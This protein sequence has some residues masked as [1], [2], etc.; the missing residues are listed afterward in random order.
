MVEDNFKVG[1]SL[2]IEQSSLADLEKQ[3]TTAIKN[4][5]QKA[6]GASNLKSPGVSS[7]SMRG[8]A[9][10]VGVTGA[11]FAKAV[12]SVMKSELS[13][14]A[15]AA[16]EITASVN[17]LTQALDKQQRKPSPTPNIT[18]TPVVSKRNEGSQKALESLSLK[19][20]LAERENTAESL[21]EAQKAQDKMTKIVTQKQRLA[22]RSRSTSARLL[23]SEEDLAKANQ[24]LAAANRKRA[25]ELRKAGGLDVGGVS[26][27]G[28]KRPLQ[29]IH[30]QPAVG[31]TAQNIKSQRINRATQGGRQEP[32]QSLTVQ[33]GKVV[34]GDPGSDSKQ[35][36]RDTSRAEAPPPRGKIRDYNAQARID[37]DNVANALKE[38]EIAIRA[39]IPSFKKIDLRSEFGLPSPRDVRAAPGAVPTITSPSGTENMVGMVVKMAGNTISRLDRITANLPDFKNE[40]SGIQ[41]AMLT[42]PKSGQSQLRALIKNLIGNAQKY[43]SHQARG[44]FIRGGEA[45]LKW[46]PSDEQA[47]RILAQGDEIGKIA[48]I[49]KIFHEISQQADKLNKAGLDTITMMALT[50]ETAAKMAVTLAKTETGFEGMVEGKVQTRPVKDLGPGGGGYVNPSRLL[51]QKGPSKLVSG[52]EKPEIT[53]ALE[54]VAYAE[55]LITKAAKNLV[56]AAVSFKHIPE[57]LEDQFLIAESAAKEMGMIKKNSVLVKEKGEDIVPGMGLQHGQIL[58]KSASGENVAMNLK[59]ASAEIKKI[60]EVSVDGVKLIKIT[61]EE[62]NNMITGAKLGDRAGHKGIAK[63]VPDKK[64]EE[65]GFA[66]GTQLVTSIEGLMKRNNLQSIISMISTSMS[67]GSQVAAQTIYDSIV[68]AMDSG[69]EIADAVR[70]TAKQFGLDAGA[71]FKD[72][73][74]ALASG[75]VGKVLTGRVA[76]FRMEKEGQTGEAPIR[77]RFQDPSG[78]SALRQREELSSFADAAEARSVELVISKQKDYVYTLSHLINASDN[79]VAGLEKITPESLT[80]FDP[81]GVLDPADIKG[82]LLDP[83]TFKGA[84]SMQ[85]PKRAGGFEEMYVPGIGKAAGQRGSS[86]NEAGLVRGTD[87]SNVWEK[88]RATAVQIKAARGEIDPTTDIRAQREGAFRANSLM[89]EQIEAIKSGMKGTGKKATLTDEGAS[90]AKQFLDMWMP[91]IQKMEKMGMT[92]TGLDYKTISATGVE[93]ISPVKGTPTKYVEGGSNPFEQAN[94]IRDLLG[95]RAGGAET[96]KAQYR[97]GQKTGAFTESVA[98]TGALF[99]PE[100]LELVVDSMKRMGSGALENSKYMDQLWSRFDKLKNELLELYN[101]RGFGKNAGTPSR[102]EG[103]RVAQT[104]GSGIV[105]GAYAKAIEFNVDVSQELSSAEKHLRSLAAAGADVSGSL[106]ALERIKN[107]QISED[108]IPRDAVILSQQDYSNLMSMIKNDARGRG[109]KLTDEEARARLSRVVT[110]R[111]PTTGGGSYKIAKVIED[112]LGRLTEGKMGIPGAFAISSTAD[113]QKVREPLTQRRDELKGMLKRSGGIGAEADS[114]RSELKN[115]NTVIDGLTHSFG[116]AMQNLDFDGDAAKIFGTDLENVSSRMKTTLEILTQGGMS[117]NQ[118][119]KTILGSL[120]STDHDF[121]TLEGVQGAFRSIV[122]R[123]EG[124]KFAGPMK[125]TAEA[126]GVD[127]TKLV[128]GKLS[129]GKLSD[130]FNILQQAITAGARDTGDAFATGLEVVMQNINKSLAAKHGTGDLAGPLEIIDSLRR[131]PAGLEKMFSGMEAGGEGAF[132]DLGKLNQK[133]RKEIENQLMSQNPSELMVEAMKQGILKEGEKVDASNFSSVIQSLVDHLDLKAQFRKM[134]SMIESNMKK[135][136]AAE[137]MQPGAIESEM[138]RMMTNEKDPG[139]DLFRMQSPAYKLTRNRGAKALRKEAGD[140]PKKIGARILESILQDANDKATT[141]L[142]EFELDTTGIK[143]ASSNLVSEVE[144]WLDSIRSMY[145]LMDES[146]LK[147]KGIN[148]SKAMGAF[149]SNKNDPTT[150]RIQISEKNR[151]KPALAAVEALKKMESGELKATPSLINFVTKS[152]ANLGM[153]LAHERIHEGS[154][155]FTD[156]VDFIVDSLISGSGDIGAARGKIMENANKLQNVAIQ[157]KKFRQ[158]AVLA[159]EDPFGT[160]GKTA[161]LEEFQGMGTEE[162]AA[163]QSTKYMRLVAEELQAHLANPEKWQKIFGDIPAGAAT[164]ISAALNKL[165]EHNPQLIDPIIDAVTCINNSIVDT[166][167][168]ALRGQ[169]TEAEKQIRSEAEA[170]IDANSFGMG[171]IRERIGQFEQALSAGREAR[172]LTPATEIEGRVKR[173]R[174]VSFAQESAMPETTGE[175]RK[176]LEAMAAKGGV[177]TDTHANLK[178]QYQRHAASYKMGLKTT[179]SSKDAWK[180]HQEAMQEFQAA[181]L[182]MYV[183]KARD[184]QDAIALIKKSGDVDSSVMDAALKEL[185]KVFSQMYMNLSEAKL[186]GTFGVTNISA[187]KRG[188]ATEAAARLNI[189]VAPGQY[190]DVI[191]QAGG[192]TKESQARFGNLGNILEDIKNGLKEDMSFTQ[193]WSMLWDELIKRP[194]HMRENVGKV[195]EALKPM[196]QYMKFEMG[197]EKA[198]QGLQDLAKTASSAFRELDAGGAIDS[199]EELNNVIARSGKLKTMAL[200]GKP[201]GE[202]YSVQ[203]QLIKDEAIA[204]QKQLNDILGQGVEI[205][206]KRLSLGT[207]DIID[208]N[209][210]VVLRKMEVGA[211]R[212]GNQFQVSMTQAGKSVGDLTGAMRGA[213]RR[214]VQWGFA[215]GIVYGTVRAFRAAGSIIQEVENK[216]TALKKVMDTSVTNFRELQDGAVGF[217]KEFGVSIEDVLDGMVVYGQQGLKVNKIMERTRATMLAVNTTTL[218]SVDATEAL[219]AAHKVF[220][221][222]IE[223]SIHFVDAWAAVAARHAITAEDL[224]DAVKRSGAAAGVAGVGFNDFLGVVTAI[225]AVTRQSG[226]E[227]ATGTKFMFRAMRRPTAQK[228][229]GKMGIQSLTPGGDFKPALGILKEIAGS[230]DTMTKAQQVNLA[231]AMAGIRHYNAFIVLMNNFDEALLASADAANSQGFAMRKN[232]LAMSTFTKNMTVLQETAKGLAITLGNVLLPIGKGVIDIMTGMTNAVSSLPPAILQA[233]ALFAGMGLA[234]HKGA[235]LISDSME[236]MS[237]G[238]INIDGKDMTLGRRIG[239]GVKSMGEGWKAAGAVGDAARGAEG[240]TTLGKGAYYAQKGLSGLAGSAGKVIGLIPGL[241]AAGTALA[242]GGAAAG[243]VVLAVIAAALIGLVAAYQHVTKSAS[244]FE[245]EQENII[246]RSEDVASRLRAQKTTADRLSLAYQK[247]GKAQE[248]MNDPAAI[249]AA[250]QEGRFKSSAKAAQ[251]YGNMLSEVSNSMARIDPSSVRGISDTGEYILHISDNFKALT[252]SA[253]D[254]RNAMT[255]A[256]KLDIIEKFA[257]ELRT[258]EGLVDNLSQGFLDAANAITGGKF[259][260]GI[261]DKGQKEYSPI[262][263]LSAVRK[264]IQQITE[265]MRQQEKSGDYSI[266]KQLQLNAKVKEEAALRGEVL[267]TAN[268]IRRILESM[269]TFEDMGMGM[270]QISEQAFQNISGAAQAGAFGRGSTGTSVLNQFAA[271]QAGLGGILDYQATQSPGL[272]ASAFLERGIRGTGGAGAVLGSEKNPVMDK[273]MA[274]ISKQAAEA[275]GVNARILWAS[276]EKT[277]GEAMYKYV[278]SV[279]GSWQTLAGSAVEGAIRALEDNSGEIANH[280]HRFATSE[281]EAASEATKKILTLQFSGAMAG[282]RIPEGGMPDL[283]PSRSQDLTAE[284]RV[285]RAMPE[286]LQRLADVQSEFNQLAKEYSEDVLDD[287]EGAYKRQAKSGSAL[288]VM[289]QEVL[290]LATKLQTEGHLITVM[291]QFQKASA[292]LAISLEAAAEASR[293]ASRE[294]DN[295]AKYLKISSGALAGM[296]ELPNLDLGKTMRELTAQETLAK[297]DPSIEKMIRKITGTERQRSADLDTL[298]DIQKKMS[299]LGDIQK[300][301]EEAGDSLSQ[302]QKE[303]ITDAALK[304]ATPGELKMIEA[305]MKEGTA[306]QDIMSQ[307]LNAQIDMLA[308]MDITNDLLATPEDERAGKFKGL[309]DAASF[310]KK[311]SGFMQLAGGAEFRKVLE[312]VIGVR[313]SDGDIGSRE[314]T[315]TNASDAAKTLAELYTALETVVKANPTGMDTGPL[316]FVEGQGS[317]SKPAEVNAAIKKF[318]EEVIT[319]SDQLNSAFNE[320]IT[321]RTSSSSFGAQLKQ[322]AAE[323]SA[324]RTAELRA[325]NAQVMSGVQEELKAAEAKYIS[326]LEDA[327]ESLKAKEGLRLAAATMDFAKSLDSIVLEMDKA[328]LLGEGVKIKSDLDSEFGRVGQPGFKNSFDQRREALKSGSN[329]PMSLTDLRERGLER[330]KIDFDEEEAAIKQKQAIETAALRQLQSQA[331]KVRDVLAT[332]VLDTSMDQGTRS[333]AQSYLETLTDQLATSEQATVGRNGEATFKG[334]PALNE[335]KAFAQEMKQRSIEQANKAAQDMQTAAVREGTSGLQSIAN[336][337]LAATKETNRILSGK[338]GSFTGPGAGFVTVPDTRSVTTAGTS[339]AALTHSQGVGTPRVDFGYGSA[340]AEGDLRSS[341]LV[342]S[343]VKQVQE[344]KSQHAS[345]TSDKTSQAGMGA[346]AVALL[347]DLFRGPSVAASATRSIETP[348]GVVTN[349]VQ[350]I[351]DDLVVAAS[352]LN[353]QVVGLQ[354]FDVVPGEGGT[355]SL[356]ARHISGETGSGLELPPEIQ[357]KGVGSG[358]LAEVMKYGQAEGFNALE[359]SDFAS[360]EQTGAYRS[361]ARKT[362]LSVLDNLEGAPGSPA[363]SVPLQAPAKTGLMEKFSNF[364]AGQ[365]GAF[366]GSKWVK[367]GKALGAIGAGLEGYQM[368]STMVGAESAQNPAELNQ[369]GGQLAGQALGIGGVAAMSAAGGAVAGPLGALGGGLI[370]GAGL[371]ADQLTGAGSLEYAGKYWNDKSGG[372][373]SSIAQAGGKALMAPGN[374]AGDAMDWWNTRGVDMGPGTSSPL[375]QAKMPQALNIPS[376]APKAK[377]WDAIVAAKMAEIGPDLYSAQQMGGTMGN[378]FFRSASSS[379]GAGGGTLISEGDLAG[380]GTLDLNGYIERMQK[381]R[382]ALA[383]QVG[384]SNTRQQSDIENQHERTQPIA[385]AAPTPDQRVAQQELSSMQSRDQSSGGNEKLVSAIDSLNSKIEELSAMKIDTTDLNSGLNDISSAVAKLGTSTLNVNVTGGSMSVDVISLPAGT[386]TADTGAGSLGADVTALGQRIEAV[387]ETARSLEGIVDIQKTDLS[388]V[389]IEITNTS[390]EI[391]ELKTQTDEIPSKISTE[392]TSATATLKTELDDSLNAKITEFDTKLL[393]IV[394]AQANTE[395]VLSTLRVDLESL[396]PE[397]TAAIRDSALA[398]NAADAAKKS[399]DASK[400]TADIAKSTADLA[401]ITADT[402]TTDLITLRN[403]V[404]SNKQSINAE[405]RVVKT[406]VTNNTQNITANTKEI[407]RVLSIAQTAQNTAGAAN[408]A[409]NRSR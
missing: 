350:K 146:L 271:G 159:K 177:D 390:A 253:L 295:R 87:E 178:T 102:E 229:L 335:L 292:E 109:E 389:Q 291:G 337:Q 184:L 42:N 33:P 162:A 380:T 391:A 326:F 341:G 227:I 264:E 95:I 275:L 205:D 344:M 249:Q 402:A 300:S 351:G 333:Q 81:G 32:P 72:T 352:H 386:T 313:T 15:E 156:S 59:G 142:D 82:T 378:T 279:D 200:Q 57:V 186:P 347:G 129:V 392:I 274:V 37:A 195:V 23:S 359:S 267:S 22:E 245:Q 138:T 233:T 308:K 372:M 12:K 328:A 240:L 299:R 346:G 197:P 330:K 268:N 310:E 7:G 73:S 69:S 198:T 276:V 394:T 401:K 345:L 19:K 403:V 262:G 217:A 31:G 128:G 24:E 241:R 404:E 408:A 367:G 210:G 41:K 105:Q 376:P 242:L 260:I 115:L 208:P 94:R 25:A 387:E 134:W 363:L 270:S 194:E 71:A 131:G 316:A 342:P 324:S 250:L 96:R 150:G 133:Y 44:Q 66:K 67:D 286:D 381:S 393:P 47:K 1:I 144:S 303:R 135:A 99:R 336:Q 190:T 56:T 51:Y 62:L 181:E 92:T 304:D 168:Q 273:E 306:A 353:G 140:D 287:V 36:K 377:D 215:T 278:S 366:T 321:Q 251:D 219:T 348:L 157:G 77:D 218:S 213:L 166:Y 40:L 239:G 83:E 329:R 4:A 357:G 235:D 312:S 237:S 187:D 379:R 38:A 327:N 21:R 27:S 74:G 317:F 369:Y 243:G 172:G 35:R 305:L 147:L 298:N 17:R 265:E 368:A 216:I 238:N 259:D 2:E 163:A 362:G 343:L 254:A 236:A 39:A 10:A 112:K 90:A 183:N 340:P 64:L 314:I 202:A 179:D 88:L 118:A 103:R 196:A 76:M 374:L 139:L 294:E 29:T 189:P 282:I 61:F 185:E 34:T 399:A 85:V 122:K 171:P 201:L 309:M 13:S 165:R 149:A 373:F 148:P 247:I 58:G 79:L 164:A 234:L 192:R 296:G 180:L 206:A 104:R 364:R 398:V 60:S 246:G 117:L 375:G 26:V 113:L 49:G 8:A 283:G 91:V 86:I 302:A 107:L 384:P 111:D 98:S 116:S 176:I 119:M 9:A 405:V 114:F 161:G 63:V 68:K 371:V 70:G 221:D 272:A 16:K 301:M 261:N 409:A 30:D 173:M 395:T 45:E 158:L 349:T 78:M 319:G 339:S 182:E 365:E 174:P 143:S 28:P 155:K 170:R 226:K 256:M 89:N 361:A 322:K 277:S 397:V 214:V 263:K 108:A 154:K 396:V 222:E 160:V 266:E 207:R 110:H 65:M 385:P 106:A 354:E 331:E 48:E 141:S 152:L 232:R 293:D 126:A 53:S 193:A 223:G 188:M 370:G 97:G 11:D 84:F 14:F 323:E 325:K 211:K 43:E 199:M 130:A 3:I 209:T 136:L 334:I 101:S 137:G 124:Q 355:K 252:T 320:A 100:N 307:Q 5:T 75:G 175:M 338:G 400:I 191:K 257:E 204:F 258:A 145:D 127:V 203:M 255:T 224:A 388:T 50:E 231:Q 311:R 407:A 54:D 228:E 248:A 280:F 93:R 318:T 169:G 230:W 20:L 18:T 383:P 288:K 46:K 151:V 52:G 121:Q 358:R 284:Q 125:D 80:G 167:A 244:Q 120:E 132:G 153:T 55:G 269:P 315:A 123:P 212:V 220:G 281:I 360:A 285:M 290:Q 297:S 356:R 289:T 332:T 406:S 225:G 6:A 382:A